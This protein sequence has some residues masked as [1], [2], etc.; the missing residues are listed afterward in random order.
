MT[1]VVDGWAEKETGK[2]GS[3]SVLGD[4]VDEADAFEEQVDLVTAVEPAQ[5]IF[6]L[7]AEL[8]HHPQRGEAAAAALGLT[9]PVTD[10][11]EARLDGVGRAQMASGAEYGDRSENGVGVQ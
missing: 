7:A 8:E 9:S 4:S 6:A 2:A 3:V 10:G 5:A 11:G 1:K